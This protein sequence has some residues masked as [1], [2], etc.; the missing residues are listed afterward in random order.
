MDGW[1]TILSY[2][3]GN[4]S[5]AIFLDC[6]RLDYPAKDCDTIRG[7]WK[8]FEARGSLGLLHGMEPQP[9]GGGWPSSLKEVENEFL[10]ETNPPKFNTGHGSTGH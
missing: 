2:W 8:A 3:E 4:F 9:P 10:Q 5:G 1:K 6:L 7:Q